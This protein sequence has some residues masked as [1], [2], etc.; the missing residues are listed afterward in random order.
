MPED[1]EAYSQEQSVDDLR[2]LMLHLGIEQAYVG[3]LSMGGGVALNFGLKYPE[4][5][6]GLIVASAGSG[7][8]MPDVFQ[9]D[10]MAM[11]ARLE[12]DGMEKVGEVYAGGP[13][14]VQLL[15][16]DPRGWEEFKRQLTGHSAA[17]SARTLRGVQLRRPTVFALEDKMRALEVPTLIMIGDEDEP[18]VD[19]SVFMKRCI[20][21][22][23]LIVFPQCGHAINLKSRPCST[24]LSSTSSPR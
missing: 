15:R 24:R 1:P 4:M 22:S 23:G 3:G 16:K 6:R 10:G 11:A 20:P 21:R 5:A 8:V 9:R 17:G 18:C 14:R 2:G 12:Q 7:S 13:T 19:P